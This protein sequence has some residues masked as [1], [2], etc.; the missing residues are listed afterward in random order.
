MAETAESPE[1]RLKRLGM[2]SWRRGTREMDLILGPFADARLGTLS[3]ET[4]D[5]YERLLGENDHDIYGW[6]SGQLA[7]P[8]HYAGLLGMIRA[9]RHIR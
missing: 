4:L 1:N 7:V 3:P 9:Q 5:L 2:R 8:D 6:I